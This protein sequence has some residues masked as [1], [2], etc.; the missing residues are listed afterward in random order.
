MPAEPGVYEHSADQ[1]DRLHSSDSAKSAAGKGDVSRESL[2]PLQR[3]TAFLGLLVTQFLGAFN[4]S[5]F[6]QLVLLLLVSIPVLDAGGQPTF[7]TVGKPITRDLQPAALFFFALSFVMFS[8]YAGYLSDRFSKRT[9]IVLCKVAEIVI[10]A[11]GIGAFLVYGRLGIGTTTIGVLVGVLFLMGAQSA[12][13]GPGKYGILPELLRERDL[14]AANGLMI[15]TMFL[16]IIFGTALAGLLLEWFGDSLW[17]AGLVCVGIAVVGTLTSLPIRR[18]LAA[19]PDARFKLEVIGVPRE[20]RKLLTRDRQ[21]LYALGVSTLFWLTA[22]LVQPTVNALGGEN[23]FNVGELR[24]SLLAAITAVGIAIGSVVAGFVS[25]GRANPIVLRVGAIGLVAFL[26]LMAVPGGNSGQFLGYGGSMAVL[27]VLGGFAGVFSVP[28]QVFLQSRP[29]KRDKGR[30]IATQNI[31]NWIGILASAG[32]Y[33]A[34]DRLTRLIGWPPSSLFALAA[35]CMLPVA[36]LYR[37]SGR[38][39]APL[40]DD[41]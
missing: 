27:L 6:K 21:L 24:T 34:G 15:M 3:D 18:L 38:D 5:V 16:A 40:A 14:P 10:M 13:F 37:P 2:P 11:L 8:G 41:R 1:P 22:A 39:L 28:L 26:L 29:P 17:K 4:D 25:R 35:L 33:F 7:D 12:F 36:I 19:S 9:V 32:I 30:T 20:M 23:Q 31:F